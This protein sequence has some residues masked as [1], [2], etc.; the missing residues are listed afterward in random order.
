MDPEPLLPLHLEYLL[1]R[2][3][4]PRSIRERRLA[5][6]RNHRRMG[7]EVAFATKDDLRKWQSTLAHLA[8]TGQHN[9]IVHTTQY[10]KWVVKSELRPD[11]PTTVVVRPRNIHQGLP[12]P[13]SD[14]DVGRALLSAPYPERA[15]IALGAFCGL[16]CM[17]IADLHRRNVR[18]DLVPAVLEIIGKGGK[19]RV[20]ALPDRVVEELRAAG[21]GNSGYLWARMDGAVGPP[22]AMRVSQRINGHLH[23][24]GI[25]GTAHALRHRYGTMLYR[26]TKDI[27]LVADLMGHS[28]TDTTRGYVKIERSFD[29]AE[30]V[31][32][33]S[34][35]VG[36]V[37]EQE[38]A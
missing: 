20:I 34:R 16:R 4:R 21:M 28:S 15:W 30:H 12:R 19:H 6:L 13:M 36:E 24:Q 14:A 32:A 27:A 38:E 29:A 1:F 17:E 2:N 35:L 26:K 31:E 22:S 9:E 10:I 11:D 23:A 18:D 25:N 7:R 8:P 3:Q 33:I 37:R 5:I